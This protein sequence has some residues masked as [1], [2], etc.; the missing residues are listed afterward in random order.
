MKVCPQC[1]RSYADSEKYCAEDGTKLGDGGTTA[2]RATSVMADDR[3]G[4]ATTVMADD[5]AY[6]TGSPS[7]VE[8]PVCGGKAQP[9]ELICNFCGTRLG[10]DSPESGPAAPTTYR[11][12]PEAFVPS[13]DRTSSGGYQTGG[14]QPGTVQIPPEEEGRGLFGILGFAAAAVIALVAGAYLAVY[15]SHRHQA[16]PVAEASP[17]AVA[18][19][20]PSVVLA[21][22]IPIQVNGDL[23]A[24][25]QR[26]PKDLAK[27]FG[28]NAAGLSD[29]YGHAL[30]SSPGLDD[31]M[32]LRLHIMP[33]GTV[34]DGSVRVSTAVNPSL[35]AEVVKLASGWKFAPA[36]GAGVDAD[37]PVVFAA[38][39]S[40]VP[41][42]E[43]DLK[44]KLASLPP[45][46]AP[47]YALSPASPAP[48]VSPSPALAA[49]PPPVAVPPVSEAPSPVRKHRRTASLP[50]PEPPLR[51]RV[52]SALANDRRLR[53]VQTYAT[54][55]GNITL[56]GKV[57][58]DNAK[59]LAEQTV[60][61][62]S[63]VTSVT[64]DLTTDTSVWAQN[65]NI[66]NQQLAAAGL[67]GVTAKVIGKTAYLSGSVKTQLDKDR[68]VSVA[69]GAA[70]VIV[71]E[72]LITI[73]PGGL[74]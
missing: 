13:S 56:T 34:S 33:D 41:G 57:F 35:D 42:I 25:L 12:T 55:G 17:S 65:Q 68:A 4:R 30:D 66:V 73:T 45:N 39:D 31:G 2:G 18:T 23:A 27:V 47:E 29:A 69:Q 52:N 58:D 43:S 74:F 11:S 54:G 9:G 32:I 51:E 20:G 53:R 36:P 24:T 22:T 61:G 16:A 5:P 64:D 44:T 60:R 49:I 19:T 48:E 26:D 1:G 6:S 40:D 50:P 37:Y 67:S 70:P 38:K 72:N 21:K 71:R 46:E 8:C 10:P 14:F 63:G 15:L 59:Q 62:V 7:G 3:A 28:D